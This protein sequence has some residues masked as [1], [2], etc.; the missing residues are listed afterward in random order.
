MVG[1]LPTSLRGGGYR[2]R[3]CFGSE[4]S[5]DR[6]RPAEVEFD[7]VRRDASERPSAVRNG[8]SGCDGGAAARTLVLAAEGV[9]R[10]GAMLGDGT[11]NRYE[12]SET[13]DEG[14]VVDT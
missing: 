14:I 9:L 6:L 11:A 1:V 3:L 5:M 8:T 4:A 10:V 7:A 2:P 13:S 12:E